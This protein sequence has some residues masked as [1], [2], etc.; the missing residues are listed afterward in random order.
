MLAFVLLHLPLV[1]PAL[2]P[3]GIEEYADAYI[4]FLI[5]P[6]VLLALRRD[7]ATIQRPAERLFWT[8]VT[9]AIL[10]WWIVLWLYVLIPAPER[11]T[12]IHLVVDGIYLLFYVGLLLAA[13][14]KPHLRSVEIDRSPSR[15]LESLGLMGLLFALIVYFILIP[16]RLDPQTYATRETSLYLYLVLD[17]VLVVRFAQLAGSSSTQRWRTLYGLFAATSMLWAIVG[18]LE[19]VWR[20]GYATWLDAV[21]TYSLWQLPIVTLVTAI[22][23]RHHPFPD[24]TE[25][26]VAGRSRLQSRL[27]SRLRAENLLV[28]ATLALPVI[29]IALSR[30]DRIATE[31]RGAQEWV[32]LGSLMTFGGL[33]LAERIQLQQ[34]SLHQNTHLASLIESTPLPIVLLDSEHRTVTC[35]PAFEALFLYSRDQIIG[36]SIDDLITSADSEDEA[37][38]ITQR[39]LKGETTYTVSRRSRSDGSRV[40]VR[41]YGIPLHA[42]DRLIG[43]FAIYQDLTERLRAERTLKESEERFRVLSEAAFEGIVLSIDGTIIDANQQA[44]DIYGFPVDQLVG[45][46]IGSQIVEDQKELVKRRVRSG[47]EQPYKID[48]YRSDRSRFTI[49]V[50]GKTVPYKGREARVTVIRD[51]TETRQ[52]EEQLRH[53]QKMEAVGR[54]A[55]GIAHD[56]SNLLT[57]IL[58]HGTM[59]LKKLEGDS[60]QHRWAEEIYAAAKRA[61]KMTQQLLAFGRKQPLLFKVLDLN[62]VVAGMEGMLQQLFEASITLQLQLAPAAGWIKADPRQ[63]EQVILNLALNARDAMPAGG[64]LTIATTARSIDAADGRGELDV[65][66]GEY[67]CLSVTDTGAGMEPET[68][69][70]VFEPFFTTKIKREGTGLGL[71]TVHGIVKQSGG[72]ITV[73]SVVGEGTTFRIFLPK[74]LRR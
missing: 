6:L 49:E 8:Y 31:T 56:F 63:L 72:G 12:V 45:A 46:P 66:P 50:R 33:M 54:L 70:R 42:D 43:V 27:Q 74:M 38:E 59:L 30:F 68:A 20:M 17:L 47:Y 18:I 67:L 69:A 3:I 40:D 1:I 7:S 5:L 11:G 2:A 52:L 15:T 64:R 44:A 24:E 71:A 19:I 55:E 26:R 51:I 13:E 61:G 65:E 53:S 4:D 10:C 36:R 37:R 9:L 48:C 23:L 41:I 14:L 62:S 34:Q 22:R 32:V 60:V 57:V 28:M 39:V 29:H 21:W 58:G 35:N 16:S 73:E 25:R